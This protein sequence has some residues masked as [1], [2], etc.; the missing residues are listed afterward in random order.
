MMYITKEIFIFTMLFETSAR[1]LFSYIPIF[2]IMM[3]MSVKN[4]TQ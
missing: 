2:I 4:Q 1:L 3:G